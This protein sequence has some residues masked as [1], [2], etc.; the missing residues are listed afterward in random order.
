MRTL[1]VLLVFGLGAPTIFCQQLYFPPVSGDKWE[2][3]D[4]ESLGFCEDS[5]QQLYTFLEDSDTKAFLLLKDGKIVLEKYFG[6][7]RQDSLWYWA[8]AGKTLTAFLTGIA[9]MDGHL[10]IEDTTSQY[11]GDGWTSMSPERESQIRIRHQLS[12]TT[13]MDDE[14][15][16]FCTDPSCLTYVADPGTRWAYH[17][18]PYTLI[19]E[20]LEAAT[21]QDYNI[22]T[23]Q[24]LEQPTGMDGLWIRLGYNRIFFSTARSMA[25][26]GLLVLNKGMWG[27]TPVL[28]DS[29]YFNDMITPSQSIN[30]SYG[31]LWWLNG[32]NSFMVP[33]S[34]FV[35]QGPL[36]P[37]A[38]NDAIFGLGAN[39]QILTVVPS[40]NIVVVR[41]GN[42]PGSGLVP[43]TYVETFWSKIKQIECFPVA[44]DNAIGKSL[45]VYPNPAQSEIQ[46]NDSP[47]IHKIVIYT[48]GGERVLAT[49]LPPAA[50]KLNIAYL[51]SGTYF[52]KA[53]TNEGR[54]F[55]ASFV[56]VK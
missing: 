17:N 9:Q 1:L 46:W 35:F 16:G 39:S 5:I 50:H 47:G 4:P 27:Q 49:E 37:S 43:V 52:I 2:T 20:V 53:F 21:G 23:N 55:T 44:Q 56:K 30:E 6:Q 38:P 15:D 24:N 18:A 34:Q 33:G 45:K 48:S 19:S 3:I 31:Y 51:R 13:G 41:M 14:T 10:N 8:S 11:L 54:I 36:V 29:A 42:D 7:F 32:Y 26:F 12:M 25:R 22:Y 28:Q 40:E